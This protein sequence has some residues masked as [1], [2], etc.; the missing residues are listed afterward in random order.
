MANTHEHLEHA[1]HA[2]HHASDPFNQRVAV[3]MAIVAAILAAISMVGHRTHNKVLQLQGDSNRL[4]GDVNRIIGDANRIG[5]DAG[6]AEVE[7]SNLFAWYQSKRLRQSEFE[8][9]AA[10]MELVPSPEIVRKD[11]DEDTKKKATEI[12]AARAKAATDWK[13]RA[14]EY[15]KSND[16]KDNLPDLLERGDEASKR[17]EKLHAEATRVGTEAAKFRQQAAE[18]S[19]EAEHVHH[20]ADRFDVA[21]LSAE[22]GLVL[23]SIALLTKKRAYWFIGL[24]AAVV[25]IGLTASAY[26][27]PHHPHAAPDAPVHATPNEQGKPH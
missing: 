2:E 16:K 12:S 11:A 6:H 18:K 15:N 27:I 1:E 4:L 24:T 25:A 13:K 22:I 5:T 9:S 26:M 17:A 23:C 3:S 21:H 14:A 10:L 19:E 8:I 7:K 20:Q